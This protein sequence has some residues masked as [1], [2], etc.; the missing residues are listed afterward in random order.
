MTDFPKKEFSKKEWTLTAEAFEVFLKSLDEDVGKASTIY[1][2][3]RKRLIRHFT[4]NQSLIAED[5]ADEV[6][7][8]VARKISEE[9]FILDKENPYPYFHGIARY[10]LLEYQREKR[11]KMLGLDDL[12]VS[13]EP[14]FDPA[15]AF[16]VIDEKM[17]TAQGLEILKQC[18][19]KLSERETVML[20]KY[21]VIAGKDK[22]LL[23]E[24]LAADYDKT[25]NALKISIN[26]IRNKLIVCAKRKLKIP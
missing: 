5:Q 10:I 14:M 15:E 11:R 22:K 3:I 21:D 18:R 7:N 2:D 19:E 25:I 26:R 17:R 13:E 1:E 8:R 9:N 20:D 6:F 12:K 23:R 16:K 4:A 24:R